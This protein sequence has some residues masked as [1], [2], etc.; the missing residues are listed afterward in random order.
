VAVGDEA[1][2]PSTNIKESALYIQSRHDNGVW[3][4]EGGIRADKRDLKTATDARSFSTVSGSVGGFYRPGDH[5]FY[6]ISL[7]H[8]ERAPSEI[9][10]FADGPHVAT[11]QFV[12]GNRNF[13]PEVGTSLELTGHW[14]LDTHFA[15]EIDAHV[16]ASHFDNFIDQIA[17]GAVEDGLDVFDYVQTNADIYGIELS[18]NHPLGK[19]AS[20]ALSLNAGY[21]YVRGKSD[22]GDVAR[23]PPQALTLKLKAKGGGFDSYIETRFVDARKKYLSPGELPTEG[24]SVVNLFTSYELANA[25]GVRLFAEIRNLTDAEIREATSVTKDTV[26]GAGRSLRAGIDVSF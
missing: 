21:D 3:G 17:T 18:V 6:G 23:I 20:Q 8:A 14:K 10:L 9:E 1:F 12:V 16:F 7:T 4:I 26:V 19:I 22:L 2:V 13:K 11:A 25:N 24:Y 15:F 5:N